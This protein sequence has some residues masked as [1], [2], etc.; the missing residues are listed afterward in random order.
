MYRGKPILPGNSD[1][2]QTHRIFKLCGSPHERNMPGYDR[3]P[4]CEGVKSFGPYQRTMENQ[5]SEYVSG[6]TISRLS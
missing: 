4:G 5:F 2:D 1:L 3:L 6:L